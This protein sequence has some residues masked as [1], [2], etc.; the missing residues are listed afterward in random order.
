MKYPHKVPY[1]AQLVGTD[2]LWEPLWGLRVQLTEAELCLLHSYAVRRLQFIHHGGCSYI[3]TQHNQSRL[4]HTLGVFSLVTYFCPNWFELRIAALLHDIGHSP[5][6]HALEHLEGFEHHKQ[7]EKVLYSP[8]I[9]NILK[10]YGFQI[11]EILELINGETSSPLR[12]ANKKIN[13][14]HLDSWVRNGVMTRTLNIPPR[15]FLSKL[16][17]K[18]DHILSDLETAESLLQ[19]IIS[20][21]RFHCSAA[22]IGPNAVLRKL[23]NSLI[24]DKILNWDILSLQTDAWLQTLLIENKSTSDEAIRLFYCP[25]E[26]KVTRDRSMILGESYTININK[27]YLS[28]PDIKN[29]GVALTELPSFHYIEKMKDLL[30]EYYIFWDRAL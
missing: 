6:S 12:N 27:L 28:E 5:F 3:N 4:Q 25:F 7:T 29:E 11:K 20:E 17:L 30:G 15:T 10:S 9:S 18:D 19:L 22:N 26:I 1:I 23:V 24:D 2:E 13:L 21:A 14:D 8:E 16:E